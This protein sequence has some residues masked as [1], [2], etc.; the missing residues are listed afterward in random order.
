MKSVDELL[1]AASNVSISPKKYNTSSRGIMSFSLVNSEG[2][3]KRF[4]MT[5][6]LITA[7]DVDKHV[8][9]IPISEEGTLLAAKKLPFDNAIKNTLK[10]K[11]EGRLVYSASIVS[12][13]TESFNLDFKNHVSMSFQNIRIDKLPDG[14]PLAIINMLDPKPYKYENEEDKSDEENPDRNEG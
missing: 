14:S 7:I 2:N 13:L 5:K 6:S 11:G 1:K 10:P 9:I 4:T 8:E 3:G 12:L